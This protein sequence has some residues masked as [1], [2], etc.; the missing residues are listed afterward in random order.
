MKIWHQDFICIKFLLSSLLSS[1]LV[2]WCLVLSCL[3]LPCLVLCSVVLGVVWAHFW[4]SWGSFGIIFGRLGGRF[5]LLEWSSSALGRSW[6][7]L[8]GSL[9]AS[10]S[11]AS[12]ALRVFWLPFLCHLCLVFVWPSLYRVFVCLCLGF[13]F[14]LVFVLVFVFSLS[15]LLFSSLVLS[16]P[17]LIL[18]LCFRLRLRL[19]LCLRLRLRLR[20]AFAP[21]VMLT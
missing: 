3:A 21:V 5:R 15:S 2:L 20:F 13:V 1:C 12:V 8:G 11:S 16:C 6:G 7:G 19:C 9:A 14:V 18:C 4:L 10:C 17:C